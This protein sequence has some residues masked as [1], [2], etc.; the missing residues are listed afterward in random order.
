MARILLPAGWTHGSET[1]FDV[2]DGPLAEVIKGFARA[3]PAHRRRLLGEDG[4][5]LGYFNVYV[6]DDPVERADRAAAE[7]GADSVVTIVP[8]LAGG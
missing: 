6:D 2:P 3:H 1:E 5:P 7:V 4:E 8:P